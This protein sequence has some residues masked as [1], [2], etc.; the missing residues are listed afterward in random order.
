MEMKQQIERQR[1]QEAEHAAELKAARDEAQRANQAKNQFLAN[2]SHEIRTPMSAILGY[3]D[4]VLEDM[5]PE[6]EHADR[7]RQPL[8][9]V[10]S[11][12]QHLMEILDDILDIC[13]IEAGKLSVDL[14]DCPVGQLATD[15]ATL[16]RHR[17]ESKGLVLEVR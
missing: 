17:A 2:V 12:G 3:V 14:V 5:D 9:T 15:V 6:S 1:E 16:L 13:R 8:L 7:W 4:L 10:R 11:N